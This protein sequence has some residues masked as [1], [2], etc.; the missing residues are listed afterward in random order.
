MSTFTKHPTKIKST[1]IA[2]A[3]MENGG[4]NFTMSNAPD[5]VV[6][7]F[8]A[9]VLTP[10]VQEATGE[11]LDEDEDDNI[12]LVVRP[13][14]SP[15]KPKSKPGPKRQATA[16]LSHKFPPPATHPTRERRAFTTAFKLGVL[17][18]ATYGRVDDG[19]GGLRAPRAKEVCERYN[20]KHTRYLHRWR[21]EEEILLL[22]KP[23]QKR[24][25]P[26]RGRWPKL[27]KALVQAFAD[28]RKERLYGR[29]GSNGR[30]RRYF[31][32][33]TRTVL[34][35][36]WFPTAG[37]IDSSLVMRYPFASSRIKLSR[38]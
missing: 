21:Q 37:S 9:L 12:E 34:Q 4:V 10:T 32:N 31:F 30:H 38:H 1:G 23:L 3:I 35:Y 19:K 5:T 18:Y 26:S 17:S 20:L 16:D 24:H 25:R 22:M 36:S 7:Q 29:S 6:L 2:E 15:R 13:P 28:R 8:A 14:L 11:A 27:E 33:F